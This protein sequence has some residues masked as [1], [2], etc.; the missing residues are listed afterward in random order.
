MD[1][2]SLAGLFT[3]RAG[4]AR[5]VVCNETYLRTLKTTWVRYSSGKNG[6]WRDCDADH[7][8]TYRCGFP[9]RRYKV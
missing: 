1:R 8:C 6:G 3:S 9:E 7:R 2:S 4:A 5:R